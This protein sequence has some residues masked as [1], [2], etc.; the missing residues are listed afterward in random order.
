MHDISAGRGEGIEAMMPAY[1][2]MPT[3]ALGA[4][5]CCSRRSK[6][7]R[8]MLRTVGPA[9][10]RFR[11]AEEEIRMA[12]IAD[13]PTACTAGQLEKRPALRQWNIRIDAGIFDVR[14]GLDHPGWG[15]PLLARQG[16]AEGALGP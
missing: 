16:Q 12:G 15:R 6:G 11:A 1:G 2:S 5:Y 9:A 10:Q 8:A 3:R 14:L 7:A 13:R 4:F